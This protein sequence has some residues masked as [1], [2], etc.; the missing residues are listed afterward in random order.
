MNLETLQARIC[1]LLK[2]DELPMDRIAQTIREAGLESTVCCRDSNQKPVT[3]AQL[4]GQIFE[5]DLAA[6]NEVLSTLQLIRHNPLGFGWGQRGGIAV[7]YRFAP[8]GM[9]ECRWCGKRLRHKSRRW[10]DGPCVRAYMLRSHWG[11]LRQYIVERDQTCRIC[12]YWSY[13]H[14]PPRSNYHADPEWWPFAQACSLVKDWDVDHIR[15]VK[16]GG[17]DDPANLRLLCGR[18]HKQVTAQQHA[19]WARARRS[20]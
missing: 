12:G 15:A 14:R 1:Q 11:T 10:C 7:P 20:A 4:Y 18:C 2:L 6:A 5:Q 17:T 8:D 3:F 13:E 16:D 9:P 19:N